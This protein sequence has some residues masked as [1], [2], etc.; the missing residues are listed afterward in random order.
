MWRSWQGDEGLGRITELIWSGLH[1]RYQCLNTN[2]EDTKVEVL[3]R[4]AH[5]AG[6]SDVGCEK[7]LESYQHG[8]VRKFIREDEHM[9]RELKTDPEQHNRIKNQQ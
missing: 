8:N 7:G 1:L 2:M 9:R 6:L 4:S 5:G 3:S